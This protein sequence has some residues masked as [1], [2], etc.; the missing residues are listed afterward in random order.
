MARS[1]KSIDYRFEYKPR[2]IDLW[3]ISMYRIYSTGLKR[4]TAIITLILGI[5]VMRLLMNSNLL[6]GTIVLLVIIW[7]SMIQPIGFYIKGIKEVRLVPKDMYLAFNK[8]GVIIEVGSEIV[9]IKWPD[10]V[11][12]NQVNKIII[13]YI[14]YNQGY[15]LTE[16]ILGEDRNRFINYLNKKIK[17]YGK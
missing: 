15:L 14:S 16:K 4:L 17:R 7:F 9:T 10:V 8:D 5:F 2:A 3:R 6:V 1:N 13:L 12:I 11:G